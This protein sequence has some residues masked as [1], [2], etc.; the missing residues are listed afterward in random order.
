MVHGHAR[1]GRGVLSSPSLRSHL[2]RDARDLGDLLRRQDLSTP[3]P[4]CPG[5][6]LA[7]LAEHVGGTH[8]WAADI[9]RSGQLATQSESV[10]DPGEWYDTGWPSLL[11]AIDSTDIAAECWS[12]GP[13]PRRAGFWTRSQAQETAL[14]LWDAQVATGQEARFDERLAADGIDEVLT[15]FFPRSTSRCAGTR[16]RQRPSPRCR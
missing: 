2:E 8:R 15:V 11:A 7:E 6:T 12:F 9:L 1:Y 4:S 16:R 3:V 13:H 14:H 5:W 10:G